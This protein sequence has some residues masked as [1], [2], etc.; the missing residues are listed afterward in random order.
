MRGVEYSI[1]DLSRSA[2]RILAPKERTHR[3]GP[4]TVEYIERSASTASERR[5]ASKSGESDHPASRTDER[6]PQRSAQF[7]PAAD[8]PSAPALIQ[9]WAHHYTT[10]EMREFRQSTVPLIDSGSG[11]LEPTDSLRL[12]Q[13][14]VGVAGRKMRFPEHPDVSQVPRIIPSILRTSTSPYVRTFF[15]SSKAPA[16]STRALHWETAVGA[17]RATDRWVCPSQS[18]RR[19][20]A[21]HGPAGRAVR[22][23]AH[24]ATTASRSWAAAGDHRLSTVRG[25]QVKYV[26]RRVRYAGGTK[27]AVLC[28]RDYAAAMATLSEE[29]FLQMQESERYG[30]WH[31]R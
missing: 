1:F 4:T 18:T 21:S 24:G 23:A 5:E 16:S 7:E 28:V 29:Q 27:P 13:Q 2:Q 30:Q 31:P 9:Q 14:L 3:V 22:R 6:H 26:C 10:E 25:E 20:A 15:S 11:L 17:M 19:R 8:V 12:R